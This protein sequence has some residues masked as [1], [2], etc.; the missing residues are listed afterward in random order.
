MAWTGA[1]VATMGST[2]GR[3]NGVDRCSRGHKRITGGKGNGVDR[4]LRGHNGVHR[5]QWEWRGPVFSWPQWGP[6]VA[7]VM[8]W[9]GALV[10]TMG[11]TGGK[12]N[13]VD[14]CPR[15]HNGVHRWEG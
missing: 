8:A 5:W 4:W 9:T 12:G 2:S 10:A 11:F 3:G 7:R 15:G 1:L 6:Q 13:G 14:R